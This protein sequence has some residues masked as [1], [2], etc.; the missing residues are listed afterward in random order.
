MLVNIKPSVAKTMGLIRR[1]SNKQTTITCKQLPH[2]PAISYASSQ[3]LLKESAYH[4]KGLTAQVSGKPMTPKS[5]VTTTI[6]RFVLFT[7]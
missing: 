2:T 4:H 1:R 3:Q 6:F 5:V 7:C